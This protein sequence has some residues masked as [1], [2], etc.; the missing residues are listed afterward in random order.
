MI[1][2]CTPINFPF[3]PG[4]KKIIFSQPSPERVISKNK[5]KKI[6]ISRSTKNIILGPSKTNTYPIPSPTNSLSRIKFPF[7]NYPLIATVTTNIRLTKL[8]DSPLVWIDVHRAEGWY[9]LAKRPKISRHGVKT[10]GFNWEEREGGM[11]SH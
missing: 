4:I 8:R 10:H 5:R 11:K 9:N 1:L 2:N 7:F 3:F 6:I